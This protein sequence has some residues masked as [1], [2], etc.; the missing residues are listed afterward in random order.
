M[1]SSGWVEHARDLGPQGH[2]CWRY[3]EPAQ[4]RPRVG[5]FLTEGLE[6]G[7]R[8]RYVGSAPVEDLLADLHEVDGMDEA[9]ARGA[10][11]VVSLGEVYSADVPVEPAAQVRTY[12]TATDEALAAGYTGLRVAAEATPLVRTPAQL[13]AFARYEHLID[14][15]MA[16][17]PFSAMC[18]YDV[19]QLGEDVVEQLACLHPNTNQG[20]VGFRLHA[21]PGAAFS[22]SLKGELD[23]S[24]E[25]LLSTALDR[26]E[27]PLR[28]GELVL[29]VGGLDFID[30]RSLL[31]LA[32][33]AR[34]RA[35]GLV[36]HAPRPGL[37]R[38]TTLLAL[39]DVRM[40][41]A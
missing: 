16:G 12:A 36:L 28:G 5:E 38:L 41:H 7:Q 27:L 37:T 17:H 10:A 24:T 13:H 22:A 2:L 15:Y 35:A 32:E 31:Q 33:H 14:Q 21:S 11:Q 6:L 4:L 26:A 3:D 9:L 29:D 1:R 39:T 34:R 23:L 30:H 20:T 40:A 18:A 8:V 25:E 19:G